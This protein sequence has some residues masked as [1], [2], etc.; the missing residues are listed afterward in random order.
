MSK[1]YDDPFEGCEEGEFN[2]ACS[3]EHHFARGLPAISDAEHEANEK[4]RLLKIPKHKR[5]LWCW[6]CG[7]ILDPCD[8]PTPKEGVEA[9]KRHLEE[10]EGAS[11]DTAIEEAGIEGGVI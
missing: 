11:W 5:T 1:G 10:C 2:M 7:F 4:A 3:V 8:F 9:F 6:V